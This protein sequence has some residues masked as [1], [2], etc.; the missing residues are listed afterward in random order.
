MFTSINKIV[1]I[2]YIL[3][4]VVLVSDDITPLNLTTCRREPPKLLNHARAFP[5]TPYNSSF[6]TKISLSKVSNA[7]ANSKKTPTA[8]FPSIKHIHRIYKFSERVSRLQASF[9][10]KLRRRKEIIIYKIIHQSHLY[11]FFQDPAENIQNRNSPIIHKLLMFPALYTQA[12]IVT[13]KRSGK[14]LDDILLLQ[15]NTIIVAML[16]IFILNIVVLRTMRNAELAD[17]IP[18]PISRGCDL[19]MV[20]FPPH[21]KENAVLGECMPC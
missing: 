6:F 10:S 16:S 5:T 4:L 11:Q 1:H 14:I 2:N 18:S 3:S 21:L 19:P 15:M 9:K 7:L 8:I 17:R 12:T 20:S 13:A